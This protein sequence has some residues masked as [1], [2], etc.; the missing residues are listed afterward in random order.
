MSFGLGRGAPKCTQR[1]AS[2]SSAPADGARPKCRSPAAKLQRRR[3][4][5][6]S[7]PVSAGAR[8]GAVRTP[9]DIENPF[10]LLL[11]ISFVRND[12]VLEMQVSSN[13]RLGGSGTSPTPAAFR[14]PALPHMGGRTSVTH[15]G[16][17]I[18]KTYDG[19]VSKAAH[20]C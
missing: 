16:R 20:R 5:V 3:A 13:A 14:D 4:H 19:T 7:W 12:R 8:K 11:H 18:R 15:K 10:R 17:T 2:V 1:V 6:P 9:A